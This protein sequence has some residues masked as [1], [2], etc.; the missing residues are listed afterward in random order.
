[1]T[2]R[3]IARQLKARKHYGYFM[4]RCPAHPD[5]DPSLSIRD[6]EKGVV[7]YC[8]AGCTMKS[9]LA[10]LGLTFGDL[11]YNSEPSWRKRIRKDAVRDVGHRKPLGE[12]EATYCYTDER[13]N[14]IAEKLRFANKVFLWRRPQAGGGWVWKVDRNALPLYRLHAVI[15][16]PVVCLTE[17]EKDV[18]SL[19]RCGAVAT[20][21]PN[22]AK[23]WKAEYA[24]Y[25]QGKTVWII[26]DSDDPGK[27]YA[28]KSARDISA[29]AKRVGIVSVAPAKDVSDYLKDHTVGDLRS[30]VEKGGTVWHG[31]SRNGY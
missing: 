16:A 10:A 24:K 18:H 1:M 4:A 3:E 9:I 19:N 2:A 26:P 30:L 6:G 23:S 15:A 8:F 11:G 25:F 17:G 29:V 22:G 21:A 12:L 5:R 31:H 28:M 7:L 13:G 27:T 14:P 20:T